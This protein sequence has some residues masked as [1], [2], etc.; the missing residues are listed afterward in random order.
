MLTA[1]PALGFLVTLYAFLITV[2]GLVW[3]LML[4]GEPFPLPARL[5]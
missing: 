4:I 2:F 3:V 1:V 5:T